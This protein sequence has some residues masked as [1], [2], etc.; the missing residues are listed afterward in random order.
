MLLVYF[1]NICDSLATYNSYNKMFMRKSFDLFLSY[2]RIG[3]GFE[4]ANLLH[5]RLT[6]AG[7]SVFMDVENLRS[8]KFNDQ[9]YQQIDACKDFIVVLGPD[10]LDRCVNDDDW[11]RLEVARAIQKGKNIIPIFLRGFTP[12]KEP[13]PEDIAELLNY[14]GLEASTQLFN[15][16]LEKLKG[17]LVSKRHINW[18]RIRKPFYTAVAPIVLLIA[19]LLF[20][21][22]NK[23]HK[24][25]I[26]VEQVCTQV[27][28]E[29]SAG[30]VQENILIGITQ[31][32]YKTWQKFHDAYQKADNTNAKNRLIKDF[33][34]YLDFQLTQVEKANQIPPMAITPAHEELLSK[35]GI[36][37]QDIKAA[38]PM[39]LSDIE[40]TRDYLLKI[41]NWLE[42][43]EMGWPS[44]LD[45]ALENL[46]LMNVELI[47]G[48]IYA[49]NEL[50]IEMP[51]KSQEAYYKFQPLYINFNA[52]VN[53]NA[54]KEQLEA[55]QEQ[56]M[57]RC[58]A[59][60]GNYESIVGNENMR[61]EKLK[62][63]LDSLKV[64]KKNELKAPNPKIDSLKRV[65]ATKKADLSLK[66]KEVDA[67][68][69]KLRE[70]YQ[71]ILQ[72]CTFDKSEDPGMMW[73]KIIFLAQ[74]ASNQIQTEK[75]YQAENERLRKEA[76]QKGQDPNLLEPLQS[77]ISSKEIF[78]EVQKRLD[79]YLQF[80]KT[81]DPNTA[82]Y[83][84]AAK[85]YYKL[86]A[87]RKLEPVG[88][89]IVGT[90]DNLPHPLL[91]TGDI[92]TTKK[93]EP[94]IDMNTYFA[95]SK[96]DGANTQTLIRFENG[97]MATVT[98]TVP[99]DC[100]VLVGVMNLWGEK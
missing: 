72:K 10:S 82:I 77:E 38:R 42:T 64:E 66:Q 16:F 97:K 70:S 60:L 57:K 37:V 32:A 47:N 8:G 23:E 13:L 3:G 26:Q 1:S 29:I 35:N 84:P 43:P 25:Q 40:Q 76:I 46:A 53:F 81:T 28:S 45:E 49:F 14:E 56:S 92:V 79:L 54:K 67:K 21:H 99:S 22:F 69:K 93:G 85:K 63:Q 33:N 98:G 30:F 48:G 89:L 19:L 31:D 9:L 6:Q 100:K 18:N 78:Q 95:L 94:V 11:V 55:D 41:K 83:I 4:T 88:V 7:Y 27:I 73:G 34:H 24:E 15:A 62:N 87:D 58:E 52:K 36:S 59:Y 91:K 80:N 68:K 44:Q 74:F 12:P 50:M 71:R 20:F 2:R 39:I 75:N 96:K 86:V 51:A 61:V 17:M 65:V 90:T 5:N